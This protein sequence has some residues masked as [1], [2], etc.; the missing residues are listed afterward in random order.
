M[1]HGQVNFCQECKIVLT[2]KNQLIE[3]VLKLD[4][5]NGCKT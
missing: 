5:G 1:H 4:I 3:N 2:F